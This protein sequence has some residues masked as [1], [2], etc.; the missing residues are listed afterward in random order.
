M[1]PGLPPIVK[2]ASRLLVDIERAVRG[3]P[4]YHRYAIGADLREDAREVQRAA[5]RAWRDRPRQLARVNQL[6]K[7]IDDQRRIRAADNKHLEVENSRLRERIIALRR[8]IDNHNRGSEDVCNWRAK[9]GD[10]EAYTS[11]DLQCPDCPRHD[12]I[13]VPA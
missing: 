3:F 13:E 12:M 9:R 1:T 11:R 6:A 10:C 7:T 4:R 8:A 2:L 5:R